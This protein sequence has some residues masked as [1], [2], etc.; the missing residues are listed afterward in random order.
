MNTKKILVCG[1]TV[2]FLFAFFVAVASQA[3]I[4][5]ALSSFSA[6]LSELSVSALSFVSIFSTHYS[7]SWMAWPPLPR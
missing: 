6:R 3:L 2:A 1:I 7:D 4:H 5:L